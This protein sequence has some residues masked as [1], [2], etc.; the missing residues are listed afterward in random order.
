LRKLRGMFPLAATTAVL[1]IAAVALAAGPPSVT[2]DHAT[3]LGNSSA[4]LNGTVNPNGQATQYAFQW[5][6]SSGYGHESTLTSAGAGT[7][8]LSESTAV[9]GLT[10]G[11]TYHYRTIAISA[12]GTS[13]GPDSS[14]TTTGTAPAPSPAPTVST[15]A[16]SSVT[17]SAANVAGTVDPKG[18]ATTYLFEYGPTSDYGFQTTPASAGSGN[19]SVDGSAGLA[20]LQSGTTYHYR[21]V[22]YNAGGT[23]LGSDRTFTTLTPPAP[24]TGSASGIDAS[25]A[26]LSGVVNPNG[27][28]TSYQFQ[29]GTTPFLGLNTPPAGVGSG[30]GEIAV[31][32]TV[33]GLA[34]NTTYYY[35]L[36]G[37]S[38]S[39][40]G[41]GQTKTFKTAGGPL[42]VSKAR[43]LV[44]FGFVATNNVVGIGTGCF[45]GQT[46]C[47]GKLTMTVGH[48]TYATRMFTL[49][50]NDG[51]FVHTTISSAGR[52]TLFHNY[53]GPVRIR[54]NVTLANGQRLSQ[55]LLFA[56]YS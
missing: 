56:L 20:N 39:G 19:S 31:H 8:Q 27:H 15:G 41:Y 54:V 43:L 37:T 35:R 6:P 21:V 18:Q 46:P 3:N 26:T 36:I 34:P 30:T 2:T 17:G 14:F 48:N 32:Q 11:T 4:T 13:V 40:T 45:G 55:V 10:P 7:T 23:T 29:F 44:N 42:V 49:A 50:A 53:H 33:T 25:D 12:S 9:A 1:A 52:R 5:G 28:S 47:T 24:T 22:A 16:S 51:G 38:S